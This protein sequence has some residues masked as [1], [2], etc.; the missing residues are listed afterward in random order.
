[1]PETTPLTMGLLGTSLKENEQRAPLDP[2]QISQIDATLRERIIVE[3]GYGERFGVSDTQLESVVGEVVERKV[4]FQRADI[5][6]LP[7]I[8]PGER[9]FFRAGQ[10]VWGWPHL[11]Q[12]EDIAQ[13]AIDKRLTMIAWESMNLPAPGGGRGLHVFHRNNEIAGYAG[14][15]HALTLQGIAGPYGAPQRAVVIHHGLT[16]RGAI[17]ALQALG[18]RAVVC[19]VHSSPE[20]V[21]ATIPG[22]TY[23]RLVC[24]NE[25]GDTSV[26]S[27]DGVRRPTASVLA[28]SDIIVNCIFQDTA[29][30]IFFARESDLSLW[31]RGTLIVD[32]S[33]DRALGFDFARPT[34]FENPMFEVGKGIAYYAVDHTPSLLWRDATWEV[35]RALLPYVSDVMAGPSGWERNPVLQPAVE[36]RDGRIL[37]PK[38]LLHQRRVAEYPHVSSGR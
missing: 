4:V 34:T 35:G 16:G 23:R 18:V 25:E 8:T 21:P 14:V 36:M 3:A 22:V 29:R 5:V 2:R 33:C 24:D 30:P 11:V 7:K 15:L 19:L 28:E 1:M 37:N 38:I 20:D 13:I 17:H 9:E 10:A 26:E 12:N 31:R 6:V 32:V 27:E